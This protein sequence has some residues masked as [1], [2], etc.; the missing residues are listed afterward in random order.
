MKERRVPRWQYVRAEVI[1]ASV[2]VK[3]QRYPMFAQF[4]VVISVAHEGDRGSF[5]RRRLSVFGYDAAKGR[6]GTRIHC[7]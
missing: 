5:N 6:L 2:D 4:V 3:V 1:A 7:L